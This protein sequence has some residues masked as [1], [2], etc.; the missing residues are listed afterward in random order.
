MNITFCNT[1]KKHLQAHSHTFRDGIHVH[2][3]ALRLDIT[4]SRSSIF[5]VFRF[6]TDFV[7][8]YRNCCLTVHSQAAALPHNREQCLSLCHS[9]T[10]TFHLYLSP[11]FSLPGFNMPA[12]ILHFSEDSI[13]PLSIFHWHIFQPLLLF[14]SVTPLHNF[15]VPFPPKQSS[16][17]LSRFIYMTPRFSQRPMWMAKGSLLQNGSSLI[18]SPFFSSQP[19][20]FTAELTVLSKSHCPSVNIMVLVSSLFY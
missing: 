2:A 15:A 7:Q 17:F 6:C 3:F 1:E 9:H 20:S 4:L 13:Y 8:F 14:L 16:F 10:L 18:S 5:K 19:K 11:T 12:F